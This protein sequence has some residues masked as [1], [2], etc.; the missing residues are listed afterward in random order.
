MAVSSFYNTEV[1]FQDY[2]ICLS[3]VQQLK[4]FLLE[5]NLPQLSDEQI[6]I[7]LLS[8]DQN[9]NFTKETIKSHYRIKKDN[10]KYFKNRSIDRPDIHFHLNNCV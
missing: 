8:C 5:E 9:I 4:E 1:L 2:N 6:I 3:E 7:F 10:P